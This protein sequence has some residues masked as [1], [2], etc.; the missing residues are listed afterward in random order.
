MEIIDINL[1]PGDKGDFYCPFTGEL[2]M[3]DSGVTGPSCVAYI[4]PPA[5]A[6]AS[7]ACSHFEKFW[8]NLL[9]ETPE[10]MWEKVLGDLDG[11]LIKGYLENY[12]GHPSQKLIGFR[13]KTT[14]LECRVAPEFDEPIHTLPFFYVVDFWCK[15]RK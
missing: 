6:D 8:D 11:E 13:I 4:P 10:E 14:T 12:S 3:D 1:P 2:Q 5:F 7:I 9:S 15:S